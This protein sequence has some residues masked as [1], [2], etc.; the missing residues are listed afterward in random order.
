[1]NI[2]NLGIK[3]KGLYIF[4]DGRFLVYRKGYL[5]VYSENQKVIE[6]IKL[7]ICLWKMSLGKLRLFERLLHIEPR[8]AVD[9]GN[10]N[11]LVQLGRKM[12]SINL[13]D[14]SITEERVSFRGRPLN[15][16][17][18]EGITGFKDSVVIG[19]Y[20]SNENCETVNIYQRTYD[21]CWAVVY[22]FQPG[23]IWHIHGFVADKD[24]NCIYIL[25]GDEDNQSGVWRA[26]NNF[27]KVE[28]IFIGSQQY[29]TCQICKIGKKIYYFTD[30]PSEPNF[31][32]SYDISLKQIEKISSIRGTCIYGSIIPKGIIVSTTCE[33]EAH[34]DSPI[35]GMITRKPGSGIKGR[36]V[37][38]LL[39]DEQSELR[40]I[41]SFKHDGLPLKLFQYGTIVFSNYN[42]GRV[43][44]TPISVKKYDMCVFEAVF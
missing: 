44:F 29:R 12:L 17:K 34:F 14:K 43:L 24:D 28:P 36:G 32:Y 15:Y 7:N 19:D 18:I 3:G 42:N 13:L 20:G 27:Q 5:Y 30:A 16:V 11:I 26:Y 1:M 40:T 39:F 23:V 31:L 41:K 38:L 9:I 10:D 8:F 22:T 4:N 25:T 21:G 6:S 37:D 35:Y 33:P 2:N